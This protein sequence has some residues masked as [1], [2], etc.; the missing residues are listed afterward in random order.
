MSDNVL[1]KGKVHSF[2]T[3]EHHGVGQCVVS[4][5]NSEQH[6]IKICTASFLECHRSGAADKEDS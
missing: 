2:G 1:D 5:H 4:L 6:T 3:P